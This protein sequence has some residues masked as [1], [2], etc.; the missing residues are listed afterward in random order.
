V[1]L[2]VIVVSLA[3]V[4][5]QDTVGSLVIV[6]FLDSVESLAIVVRACR[7]TAADLATLV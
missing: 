2:V 4:V 1:A 5:Y 3:T 7:V 6:G